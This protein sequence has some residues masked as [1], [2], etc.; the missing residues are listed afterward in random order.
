MSV[1]HTKK[2]TSRLRAGK[3]V[4]GG[5]DLWAADVWGVER[6]ESQMKQTSR[7][8]AGERVW[9]RGRICGF[10]CVKRGKGGVESEADLQAAGRG[11]SMEERADMWG[12]MCGAWKGGRRK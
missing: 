7:P 11:A 5:V 9:R 1:R 3:R 6:E 4:W 12:W 8:R 2:R 10:G